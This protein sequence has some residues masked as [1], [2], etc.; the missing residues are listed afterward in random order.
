MGLS[1]GTLRQ[2]K[3]YLTES[4]FG[5]IYPVITDDRSYS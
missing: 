1:L 2:V 5:G 4:G 3:K